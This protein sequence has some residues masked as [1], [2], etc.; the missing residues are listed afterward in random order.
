MPATFH[1][2]V[3]TVPAT[4]E[5]MAPAVLARFQKNTAITAGVTAAP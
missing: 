5:Q 3:T 2:T 4:I 1:T